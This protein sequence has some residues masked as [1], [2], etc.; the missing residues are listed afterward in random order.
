MLSDRITPFILGVFFPIASYCKN[1]KR[2]K[3]VHNEGIL[4]P[5]LLN[6]NIKT[7]HPKQQQCNEDL[8]EQLW[9]WLL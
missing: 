7:G 4:E 3:L 9:F 1:D 2:K 6:L 5:L 8:T